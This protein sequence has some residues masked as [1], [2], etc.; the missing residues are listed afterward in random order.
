MPFTGAARA[1]IDLADLAIE[2]FEMLA[3]FLPSSTFLIAQ[4]REVEPREWGFPRGVEFLVGSL[5]VGRE[6]VPLAAQAHDIGRV[7]RDAG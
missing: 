7:N 1:L 5:D 4:L 2:T 6:I 3:I